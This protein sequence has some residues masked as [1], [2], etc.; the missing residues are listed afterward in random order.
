MAHSEIKSIS[1]LSACRIDLQARRSACVALAQVLIL[2]GL[3]VIVIWPEVK[4]MYLDFAVN[5]DAG[6]TWVAPLIMGLLVFRWRENLSR[7]IADQSWWGIA[8]I[9]VG[10]LIFLGASWPFNFGLVRRMSI[11]PMMIGSVLLVCGWRVAWMCTSLYILALLAIPTGSRYYAS[12]IIAPETLTL[13]YA[14]DLLELW[15]SLYIDAVGP[16]IKYSNGT[17]NGFIA[18][19]ESNRGVSMIMP[20][21]TIGMFVTFASRRP[22]WI[23]AACILALVPIALFCNFIR[24]IALAVITIVTN[25]DPASAVPRAVAAILSLFLAYGMCVCLAWLLD[26]FETSGVYMKPVTG[27]R[28]E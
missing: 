1:S 8:L 27:G 15:P 26:V 13:H 20:M 21:L 6:H 5:P 7:S 11:V 17:T 18:L 24:F 19:G 2:W 12:L 28:D 10:V 9:A 23:A 14:A 3:S 16:D 4:P 25:A 22:T